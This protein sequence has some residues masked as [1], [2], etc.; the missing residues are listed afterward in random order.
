MRTIVYKCKKKS[1]DLELSEG[2]L[3]MEINKNNTAITLQ[4]IGTFDC[5][6]MLLDEV[7]EFLE[8][9]C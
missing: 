4:K 3:F 7:K 9:Y 8:T 6:S 1:N 5:F 2:D